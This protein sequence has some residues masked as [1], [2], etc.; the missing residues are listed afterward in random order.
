MCLFL[1]HLF[2]EEWI[3]TFGCILEVFPLLLCQYDEGYLF[4]IFIPTWICLK[5]RKKTKSKTW[6][7]W[8]WQGRKLPANG[9]TVQSRR[10]I[11]SCVSWT[12]DNVLMQLHNHLS[13]VIVSNTMG[14]YITR[15]SRS[16]I[17]TWI[18]LGRNLILSPCFVFL[19]FKETDLKKMCFCFLIIYLHIKIHLNALQITISHHDIYHIDKHVIEL[20]FY[21]HFRSLFCTV[22][23]LRS[24]WM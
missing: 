10:R 22:Y 15:H 12:Q 17:H 13:A 5:K 18:S 14:S 1:F 3:A 11:T 2:I 4:G 21:I 23:C 24:V 7:E 6:S 9:S 20:V 19:F 8:F 16:V